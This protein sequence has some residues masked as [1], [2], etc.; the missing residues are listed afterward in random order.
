M[1]VFANRI[2]RAMKWNGNEVNDHFDNFL[3]PTK[4]DCL[5]LNKNY[6]KNPNEEHIKIH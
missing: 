3:R 2:L 6:P 4:F 5:L 1:F